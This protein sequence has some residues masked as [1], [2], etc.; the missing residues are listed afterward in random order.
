MLGKIFNL[1]FNLGLHVGLS[2]ER[3]HY[4][5]HGYIIGLR[6]FI[7]IFDP[8]AAITAVRKVIMFLLLSN[9]LNKRIL[10]IIH[11]QEDITYNNQFQIYLNA[12][13]KEKNTEMCNICHI[14]DFYYVFAI[15][16]F[17]EYNL[18]VL[19]NKTGLLGWWLIYHQTL[20]VALYGSIQSDKRKKLG[21]TLVNFISPPVAKFTTNPLERE[22]K[23][24]CYLTFGLL[25]ILYLQL[26]SSI[27]DKSN[28]LT[29]KIDRYIR[30]FKKFF[31]FL[32]LILFLRESSIL[33]NILYYINPTN[34]ELRDASK[35]RVCSI[36]VLNSDNNSAL[37]LYPI[38]SNSS[39]NLPKI[40]FS[41]LY[42]YYTYLGRIL[43][44]LSI[45]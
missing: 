13:V 8:V 14:D 37:P 43:L 4:S 36:S 28:L 11:Y 41:Y 42:V 18:P 15:R 45:I 9:R 22:K 19:I 1:F 7:S 34:A 3:M 44:T 39:N 25:I 5:M 23:L 30:R 26:R 24:G 10:P 32:K 35:L 27:S 12:N 20:K 40:F 2:T 31:S 17:R 38:P 6:N 16:F 33:P 21:K 29:F